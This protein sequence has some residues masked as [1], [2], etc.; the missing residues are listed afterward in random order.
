VSLDLLIDPT[1]TVRSRGSL[2]AQHSLPSLLQALGQGGELEMARLRPHQ[3]HAWHAFLV[4]VAGLIVHRAGD[5]RVQRNEEEW[6]A[7]LLELASGAGADAWRLVVE[8]LSRPA[9]MQPPVPE[10]SLAGFQK[11][12]REPDALDVLVTAKNHDEKQRRMARPEPEH[13]V[14]ALVT[15]QTMEGFLGRGNYGIARMN[16]GF[17]SRPGVGLAPGLGWCERFR[18]D[19][20][21]WLN[22]R[23]RLIDGYGYPERGGKALLWL[24]PWTGG[25]GESL[26]LPALDPFFVEICRR[27]RLLGGPDGHLE[28]LATN[29]EAARVAGK[30]ALGNTGDVWTPVAADG[31]GL[32]VGGGGFHYQLLADLLLSGDYPW[33]AALEPRPE[34]GEAPIVVAQVLVRGQGETQGF[35]QRIV[36]VPPHVRR[37]LGKLE[38][39]QSLGTLAQD[40]VGRA[41]DASRRVLHPALCALLQG[42]RDDIDFRDRRTSRWLERL[43]AAVDRVFFEDLWAVADLDSE[44]ARRQWDE[45]LRALTREQLD[46][47]IAE[48]PTPGAV[49]PKAVARAEIIYWG[50]A[51][52]RLPLAFPLRSTE[53]A[54]S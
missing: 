34:D 32:T 27:V 51:R 52:K 46:A 10:G 19:V 13:W 38:E 36:P 30:E 48:A 35:H 21:V 20:L 1:L 49:H 12:L 22:S 42:G 47:A 6:R 25:K 41:K 17:A 15:L 39:R 26:P 50:S 53:E 28:A 11:R 16:G 43:D 9:F 4:Q 2:P 18:R 8:D 7:G 33:R 44:E 14:Y 54:P 37:K 3:Q 23:D 40:R 24:E 31:K 45:R 29:T 5:G